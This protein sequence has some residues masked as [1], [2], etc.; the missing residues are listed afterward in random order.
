MTVQMATYAATLLIYLGVNTIACS[1]LNLQFGVAG[2]MNF[3]FI[4]FQATGAYITA[5]LTLPHSSLAMA[6]T[7]ILGLH[8]PWPLPLLGAMLA[9][10]ILAGLIGSFALRP[11][12]RDFQATVMLVV[13]II[14]STLVVTQQGWFNGS[15][16]LY[17]VPHPFSGIL[18]VPFTTLRLVLPRPDAAVITV[19]CVALVGR[20]VA[21]PWGRRLR[22]MRENQEAAESL[23]TNVQ[24]QSLIV[25]VVGGALAALSGGLLVEFLSAWSPAAW[26]T[27]ETFIYFVAIIVGGLG[28]NF[29]A[30]FGAFFVLGVF[31]ELPTLPPDLCR[32]QHRGVAPGRGDRC[33]DPGLPLVATAGHLPRARRRLA[34]FVPARWPSPRWRRAGR[35]G[36]TGRRP[37]R[38][39]SAREAAAGIS[40]APRAHALVVTRSA[41]GLRRSAR[42]GLGQLRAPAGRD[43]RTDRP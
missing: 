15:A 7:Y 34:K 39:P 12:R 3:A 21:A 17:G 20:L 27:G 13:S 26:G 8:L 5:V 40:A 31:L 16:G 32:C 28:S 23:G 42:S 4:L 11:Q 22:A 37:P 33:A 2:V 43:H 24:A 29:G 25:Y 6:E 35:G 30:F 41:A 1:A 10:A 9:G 19:L 18:N 38:R 36:G 14:A